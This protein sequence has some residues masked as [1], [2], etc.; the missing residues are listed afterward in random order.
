LKQFQ[1]E[2]P[3]QA[4]FNFDLLKCTWKDVLQEL[5]KAQ[6]AKFE[7]EKRGKKLHQKAWRGLGTVGDIFAPG[8]VGIPNN[9][10][11]CVLQGGLAV[12]FSVSLDLKN[13]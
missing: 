2:V 12:I 3:D 7:D 11:L 5:E 4:D 10:P 1:I 8:L 9:M 6:A 13:A